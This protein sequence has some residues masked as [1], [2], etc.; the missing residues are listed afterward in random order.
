M[1]T[2]A[3]VILMAKV[4]RTKRYSVTWHI[5]VG[6]C[7]SKS[8]LQFVL[9]KHP[10]NE[11]KLIRAFLCGILAFKTANALKSRVPPKF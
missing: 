8:R 11:M 10:Q 4:M 7:I 6:M 5:F 1:L 2:L 3:C 9:E